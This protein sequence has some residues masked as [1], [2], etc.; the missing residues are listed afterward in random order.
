MQEPLWT[1]VILAANA[2][3]WLAMELSGGSESLAVLVRFGAK[4]NPAIVAGEY[5]RFVTPIFMHIGFLHLGVNSYAL[6][7]FGRD[8]ERLFGRG[9]FL[10]MYLLSGIGGSV[11][12]FVGNDALSAGASGAIFGLVGAMVVYLLIYRKQFGHGGQRQLTNLLF[13]VALNLALGFAGTGID[14]LGHIG[15][16]LAGLALG[17]GYCPRYQA[18]P[19]A[20]PW[21]TMHLVDVYSPA[22][23]WLVSA[24]VAGTLAAIA[25]AGVARWSAVYGSLAR[26]L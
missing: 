9:R 16:L 10:A 3:V 18:V 15:G 20:E 4:Y 17:W 19:S 26:L 7:I 22:R 6:L 24:A 25:W 14:N 2:L 12:S 1:Y 8:V 21:G 13:V 5:W 23:A 11:A